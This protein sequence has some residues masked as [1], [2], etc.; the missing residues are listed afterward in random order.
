MSLEEF[1]LYVGRMGGSLRLFEVRRKQMETKHG[2][3]GGAVDPAA[4][5]MSLLEAA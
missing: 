2:H 1:R 3:V 4:V 5:R